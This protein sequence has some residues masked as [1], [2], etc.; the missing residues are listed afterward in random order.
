[1]KRVNCRDCRHYEPKR[2]C[3]NFIYRPS[4]CIHG[5]R[6]VDATAPTQPT[7]PPEPPQK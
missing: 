7:R 5:K 1:M 2:K 6:K 3:G 4:N